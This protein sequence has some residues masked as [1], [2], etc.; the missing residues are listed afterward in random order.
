MRSWWRN[1]VV[2]GLAVFLCAVGAWDFHFK[3]QF[4]PM[5]ERGVVL[6]RGAQYEDALREF[7]EAYRVASNE[8]EVIVMLGWTNLKLRRYEEARFYFQRARRLDPRNDE[9]QL[10]MAFLAW[11]SGQHLDVNKVEKLAARHRDDADVRAMLQAAR[12]QAQ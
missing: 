7:A 5:Y 1:R 11:H 4:R 2:I 8:P 3:P 9:G 6:Y 12:R 10:G